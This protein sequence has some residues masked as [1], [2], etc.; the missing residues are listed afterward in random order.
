MFLYFQKYPDKL[1]CHLYS[2]HIIQKIST[3]SNLLDFQ[4]LNSLVAVVPGPTV[5]SYI[6]SFRFYYIASKKS[7]NGLKKEYLTQNILIIT[8]NISRPLF[9]LQTTVENKNKYKT[10]KTGVMNLK[11]RLCSLIQAYVRAVIQ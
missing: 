1:F 9:S 7:W 4:H 11:S 5:I 6:S 8:Q 10:D 3:R 2:V